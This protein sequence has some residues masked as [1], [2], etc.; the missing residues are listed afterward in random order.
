MKSNISTFSEFKKAVEIAYN[1][2][3]PF[4]DESLE[5]IKQM[6]E[7]EEINTGK[8][9]ILD[10]FLSVNWEEIKSIEQLKIKYPIFSKCNNWE[11][12]EKVAKKQSVQSSIFKYEKVWGRCNIETSSCELLNYKTG[13]VIK[14]GNYDRKY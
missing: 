2:N 4:C 13:I 9:Y 8:E 1:S 3:I 5:L 11:E 12:V 7:D 14:K 10:P 6:I